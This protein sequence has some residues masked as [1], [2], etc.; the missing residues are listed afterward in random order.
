MQ[1]DIA[2]K[3]SITSQ[4]D[5]SYEGDFTEVCIYFSYIAAA[6]ENLQ[7]K[8]KLGLSVRLNVFGQSRESKVSWFQKAYANEV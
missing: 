6:Q 8:M 5:F 2:L 4:V 1:R 3:E 7:Y